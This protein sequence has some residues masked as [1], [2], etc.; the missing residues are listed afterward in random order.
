MKETIDYNFVER[1]GAELYSVQLLTGEWL[2]V[3][4]T[5]GRVSIKEDRWKKQATLHFDYRIE[6]TSQSDHF[7]DDLLRSTAFRNHIGDVLASILSKE[8]SHI[9]NYG[10]DTQHNNH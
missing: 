5:Y 4:Y 7:T 9:G 1:D 6:D 10:K 8:D 3:I 2:G